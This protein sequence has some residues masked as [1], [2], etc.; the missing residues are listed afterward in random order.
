MKHPKELLE[1]VIVPALNEKQ[2]LQEIAPNLF[3][4]IPSKKAVKKSIKRGLVFVN[5]IEG[6][7]GTFIYGG[8]TLDLYKSE[9]ARPKP[10]VNM[11]IVVL[12][13][14][15]YLA[16]IEKPAG[17]LVSGNKWKTVE[18]ALPSNLKISTQFDA[19]IRPEPI[20]RLDFPTT[21]A[22]LIGKTRKAVIE[23]NKLFEDHKIQKYYLAVTIGFMQDHGLIESQIGGKLAKSEYFKLQTLSSPKYGFLNLVKLKLY[24]GRRHQLRIHMSSLGNPIFGDVEYGKKDLILKG[25]GLYLHSWILEFTHPFTQESIK[26]Q[27]SIPKKY[28]KLFGNI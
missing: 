28:I 24:T 5:G 6:E 14:D 20:H 3:K 25:K 19:L 27:T 22:L 4:S 18:N 2:R 8:E 10:I 13:E 1:K 9:D 12:Y 26:I 15:E 11:P 16:V 7:T 17:I 23:L 21:G